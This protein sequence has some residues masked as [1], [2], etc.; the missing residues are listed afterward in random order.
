MSL[1]KRQK[2]FLP[3]GEKM[4]FLASVLLLFAVLLTVPAAHAQTPTGTP[5]STLAT[6]TAATPFGGSGVC[7]GFNLYRAPGGTT[8]Y[9][10]LNSTLISCGSPNYT[11]TT[12]VSGN[13]YTYCATAVDSNSKESACSASV[14]VTPTGV[15]PPVLSVR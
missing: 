12:V 2:R 6:I 14:T 5:P 8:T 9:A 11:D 10:K 13:P 4:K 3:K 7:S 1:S 15:N